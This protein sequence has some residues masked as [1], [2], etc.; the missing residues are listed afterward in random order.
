MY[1]I[2]DWEDVN[3]TDVAQDKKWRAAVN[4]GTFGFPQKI[5]G[6]FW[7][8]E[9]LFCFLRRTA[10]SSYLTN[11]VGIYALSYSPALMLQ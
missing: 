7:L 5:C 8:R 11:Q 4:M 10:H 6:V 1:E 3:C 2:N 9:E